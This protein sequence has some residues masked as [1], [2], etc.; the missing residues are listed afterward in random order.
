LNLFSN[1]QK[2]DSEIKEKMVSL[3]IDCHHLKQNLVEGK[4]RSDTSAY[5]I[6]RKDKLTDK[7]HELLTKEQDQMKSHL[8]QLKF[9][10]GCSNSPLVKRQS[11]LGKNSKSRI[12]LILPKC[13]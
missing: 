11:L 4:F 10:P 9:K 12:K 6:F 7:I 2:I 13:N 8:P 1:L 5:L 3:G